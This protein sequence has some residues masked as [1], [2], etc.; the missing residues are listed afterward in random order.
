[1]TME[2]VKGIDNIETQSFGKICCIC[3][4]SSGCT[5]ECTNSG[6]AKRWHP[7]CGLEVGWHMRISVEN[8]R[9]L[10]FS[11]TTLCSDHSRAAGQNR[12][13]HEGD[14]DS[15]QQAANQDQPVEKEKDTEK[16]D[17]CSCLVPW[18]GVAFMIQ[19]DSCEVWYHGACVGIQETDVAKMDTFVCSRCKS[20]SDIVETERP[21]AG[22]DRVSDGEKMQDVTTTKSPIFEKSKNNDERADGTDKPSEFMNSTSRDTRGE[23]DQKN[24]EGRDIDQ[25]INDSLPACPDETDSNGKNDEVNQLTEV[26][27]TT[28]SMTH[29]AANEVRS[30]QDQRPVQHRRQAP[31]LWR[32]KALQ[33]S[34]RYQISVKAIF[35]LW[36]GRGTDFSGNSDRSFDVQGCLTKFLT[37][38]ISDIA[39]DK[40]FISTQALHDRL[41]E[42]FDDLGQPIPAPL[43]NVCWFGR[44][45]KAVDGI[46]QARSGGLSGFSMDSATV[47]RFSFRQDLPSDCTEITNLS[48]SSHVQENS[49]E[50][51]GALENEDSESGSHS[52]CGH[53]CQPSGTGLAHAEE[54]AHAPK[55]QTGMRVLYKWN[56]YEWYEGTIGKC[57]AKASY[58]NNHYRTKRS[59]WWSVTWDDGEKDFFVLIFT[60][61]LIK[62]FLK[63][64]LRWSCFHQHQNPTGMFSSLEDQS[65][66]CTRRCLSFLLDQDTL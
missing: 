12:A 42:Y 25:S 23:N 61:S 8:D 18:D 49:S 15:D 22:P 13:V 32:K 2:L 20:V 9:E 24:D 38:V 48:S 3:E 41:K 37:D 66:T 16:L 59:D 55:P 34:S 30:I 10:A 6:C 19:C 36:E 44:Y 7:L 26:L 54:T 53:E 33:L 11:R 62:S 40:S 4:D 56:E 65:L 28:K 45:M 14:H 63:A 64:I 1:M 50:C 60:V 27:A 17:V 58:Y 39:K 51:A 21:E 57:R 35:G 46:K 31:T 29:L 43:K 47:Q 52:D 5:I